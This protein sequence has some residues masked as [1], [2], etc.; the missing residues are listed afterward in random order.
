MW[1]QKRC[2]FIIFCTT[3][4]KSVYEDEY[5]RVEFN[6][7]RDR[8]LQLIMY[9]KS[10]K[11]IYVDKTNSFKYTGSATPQLLF[12]NSST[13]E[14]QV[15][16]KQ[17]SVNLGVVSD[18]LGIGG[19]AGAILSGT[20]VGGNRGTESSSTIYEDKIY[21]IAPKSS[22]ELMAWA[23]PSYSLGRDLEKK[24]I[25]KDLKKGLINMNEFDRKKITDDSSRYR[26]LVRYSTTQLFEQYSD[27]FVYTDFV[28]IVCVLQENVK[29]HRIEML[30]GFE[31]YQGMQYILF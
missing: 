6:L 29:K 1:A 3:V 7:S 21:T 12:R 8:L 18:V 31:K 4:K 9:N 17:R 24:L 15:K 10:D 26:G 19:T 23:V 20:N 11:I 13:T 5:V 2:Q 28:K 22:Y 30:E 27:V 25:N 16:G 14:T